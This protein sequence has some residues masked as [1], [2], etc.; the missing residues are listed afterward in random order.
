VGRPFQHALA[1]RHVLWAINGKTGKEMWFRQAGGRVLG[2]PFAIG[3]EQ[4]RADLVATI[5]RQP[6]LKRWIEAFDGPT[7][8]SRWRVPIDGR[9]QG[10]VSSAAQAWPITTKAGPRIVALDGT[11]LV[12][13]ALADGKVRARHELG[14]RPAQTPRFAD[15]DGDGRPEAVRVRREQ[16]GTLTL[17]A[18][19]LAA[20]KVAW[21][22]PLQ[23]KHEVWPVLADLDGDGK[24]EV[25]IVNDETEETELNVARPV[26]GPMEPVIGNVVADPAPAQGQ[27]LARSVE[28]LDGVTGQRRWRFEG[29]L[30]RGRL[31]LAGD[32]VAGRQQV[33]VGPDVAGEGARTVVVLGQLAVRGGQWGQAEIEPRVLALSG[34]DGA[35]LWQRALPRR[36][37]RDS[38]VVLGQEPM[39][40]GLHGWW[41]AGPHGWPLLVVLT[42]DSSSGRNDEAMWLL[43]GGTGEVEHTLPGAWPI[44]RADLDGDG[45]EELCYRVYQRGRSYPRTSLR[46]LRGGPPVAW[47][48]LGTAQAAGDIDG[49]GTDDVID[50]TGKRLAVYSGRDGRLLWQ[51]AVAARAHHAST[52]LNGDGR[53]DVLAGGHGDREPLLALSG[54]DGGR[55]WKAKG[56]LAGGERFAGAVQIDCRDLNGTGSSQVLYVYRTSPS[57]GGSDVTRLAVLEGVSGKVRWRQELPGQPPGNAGFHLVSADLDGDGTADVLVLLDQPDRSVELRAFSGRDG[58]VL[59]KQP[60]PAGPNGSARH[61]YLLAADLTGDDRSEVVLGLP[62]LGEVRILEGRDGSARARVSNV[63][64]AFRPNGWREGPGPMVLTR[65]D[66]QWTRSVCVVGIVSPR[67]RGDPPGAQVITRIGVNGTSGIVA[68]LPTSQNLGGHDGAT[69]LLTA[70]RDGKE[71]LFLVTEGHVEARALDGAPRWRWRVP[72]DP[73]EAGLV[74][75]WPSQGKTSLWVVVRGGQSLF[76]LDAWTGRPGW[77][78]EVNGAYQLLESDDPRGWPR[79]LSDAR[80][81]QARECLLPLPCDETGKYRPTMAGSGPARTAE[82]SPTVG[83]PLPWARDG[84]SGTA[85]VWVVPFVLILTFCLLRGDV[86]NLLRLLGAAVLASTVVG[87]FLLSVDGARPGESHDFSG[88]YRVL[89]PGLATTGVVV[90]PALLLQALV[91][92][93]GWG[94]GRWVY[95]LVVPALLVLLGCIVP[96]LFVAGDGGKPRAGL[97]AAALVLALV[98][99]VLLLLSFRLGRGRP[100]P[101]TTAPG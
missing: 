81:S 71:Q 75:L 39:E 5:D 42:G 89:L 60:V 6:G 87:L 18:F 4:G 48:R 43:S 58:R 73:G 49:D 38:A 76:G 65:R 94:R 19:S 79:I 72:G 16:A 82:D 31:L 83:R 99:P 33:E 28:V 96:F 59:W 78:C 37:N 86:A 67:K 12:E 7:G 92:L 52:D 44:A 93:A 68:H 95:W 77:R 29:D 53:A 21:S 50:R 91:R 27:W 101:E 55:L 8:V 1:D 40:R 46:V 3:G 25:V 54:K 15:L 56:L 32:G 84:L 85:L 22:Y 36:P 98:G 35:P 9:W 63:P 74:A 23:M 10:R 30:P 51:H 70:G 66:D 26:A 34:K 69:T 57:R 90:L 41:S 20:G 45:P 14:F 13:L 62:T 88:W 80:T 11:C 64:L 17:V 2:T 24:A 61:V 100:R 97:L 47:R